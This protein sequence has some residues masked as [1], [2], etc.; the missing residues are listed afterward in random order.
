MCTFNMKFFNLACH[1]CGYFFIV[2]FLPVFFFPG[3]SFAFGQQNDETFDPLDIEL[4]SQISLEKLL[5]I[6][7]A[8][9]TKTLK[10]SAEVPAIMTVITAQEIRQFGYQS[11]AEV[12]GHVTGFIDSYD[13]AMHNFGVRGINS[14][15]RS[16]SRTVKFMID[17]NATA[18]RSTSQNFIDQEFIPMSMVA[19][20]EIIRGPVSALYGANAFLGVVNIVTKEA[21]S[22]EDQGMVSVSATKLEHAGSGYQLS[23]VGGNKN[24][25]SQYSAG[26]SVAGM[27]RQGIDLPRRSPDYL[28][29]DHTRASQPD[30][31]QSLN[32]YARGDYQLDDVNSVALSAYFQELEVDN[33]FTDL[34]A[35]QEQGAN[36]IGYQ[37]YFL[38][39][40]YESELAEHIVL[41]SYAS[42]S[43]GDT[44]D[45][46][47]VELGADNFYL[48]RRIGFTSFDIGAEFL[49]NLSG[50]QNV[51]VGFESRRDDQK[52]ETFNRVERESGQETQLS[53]SRNKD[54]TDIGI[55]GQYQFQLSENWSG[56]LGYRLDDDSIIEQNESLR[57]GLVGQLPWDMTLK[58]LVGSAFQAPSPELLFRE[59]AQSGDIIG[60]EALR[61]QKAET[62]EISLSVPVTDFLHISG[63]LYKTKVKDLVIFNSNSINLFAENSTESN[64]EGFELESRFQYGNF[65]G[66]VNYFY[67]D[68]KRDPSANALYILQY[69]PKGE[70]FP[71]QAANWGISYY[72]ARAKVTVSLNN[73]WVDKRPASTLNVLRAQGHY[74]LAPY[75]DGTLTVSMAGFSLLKG[76]SSQLRLQV[77]DLY[78]SDHVDAGFG[79]IDFPSLG[80]RFTFTYEQSF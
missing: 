50:G 48:T 43:R 41:R 52:L 13:L 31:Y 56:I 42:F 24:E 17:G 64:T 3:F 33:Y 59:S 16:G 21:G 7:V 71:E 61:A 9:A 44:T 8:V 69:N 80:R 6:E 27:D 18:F 63:T 53:D 58:L 38:T 39:L 51:L 35:L 54:I 28:L 75:I 68:T 78:N 2:A 19:R 12:L 77:R 46:D 11:V 66:Y 40:A 5:N 67:Q 57:L 25:R 32:F 14:G 4:L 10:S 37:N 23:A 73:R 20:I 79:G 22:L 1:L 62:A 34:N 49:L 74:Q 47:K 76:K 60:N 65:T 55:Y 70:L 15:V 72:H 29:F 30:D 26:F 45:N 36:I